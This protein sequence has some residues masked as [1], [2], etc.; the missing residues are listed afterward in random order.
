MPRNLRVALC[1]INATVGDLEGNAERI[2][3]AVDEARAAAADLA[4]LPELGLTGYP[5]EDLLLK[6]AFVKANLNALRRLVPRLRGPACLVGFAEPSADGLYNSLAFVQD[7]RIR[8]VCRKSALPNYA[9]FDEKRYF[10]SGDRPTVVDLKGFRILLTVCE[11]LWVDDG[12]VERLARSGRRVD[13]VVNASA[14]PYFRGRIK[15]RIALLR[16]KSRLARA[17]VCLCNLVGGQDELVFDGGSLAVDSHGRLLCR[18]GQFREDIV[19]FDLPA[20]RPSTVR[21]LLDPVEE[22]YTALMTGT[23]DYVEKSGFSKVVLGLSGGIDSSLVAT[24]AVDALGPDRVV[25]VTM[26]SEFSSRETYEDALR[27]ASNLGIPCKIIPI[28][29]IYDTYIQ[30]FRQEFRDRP[31]DITEENLQARIRGN[32]LMALSNKYG[33]LVLT[34]GNKSELSTGYSTLYGDMAGGFGVI[35]DVYKT[36]VYRLAAFANR[37]RERIPASVIRRPPTAELRPGQKDQDT[38]P[39]YDIL[40]RILELYIE[41][42]MPVDR[43]VRR[44]FDRT[45]VERVCRMVDRNEYKRRQA[46]PGVR[47]TPKA[48]G[49]DRR[50]PIVN[51]FRDG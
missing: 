40:D 45:L 9:V 30:E 12:P 23:R 32:I 27:T 38:L 37:E 4:V 39:P 11:D 19:T 2:R 35:K 16:R 15:D 26:P 44:G 41:A 31:F 25:G 17:A 13:L 43:I 7:G 34:T 10:V 49:K 14:S 22:V 1:Q 18:A 51:R 20:L 42:D 29:R 28:R 5:P 36:L 48:F 33:W 21:P 24:I 47:I 50:M 3:K 6:P 46:P 8:A